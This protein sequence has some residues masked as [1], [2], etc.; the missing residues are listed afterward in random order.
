MVDS[1]LRTVKSM[2]MVPF[3]VKKTAAPLWNGN[4]RK[5]GGIP[6]QPDVATTFFSM[7]PDR[8][9]PQKKTEFS[10]LLSIRFSFSVAS[11]WPWCCLFSTDP[12][13]SPG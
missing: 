13:R 8:I 2:P 4:L 3:P 7:M 6:I 11:L 12:S 5:T 1:S 9:N 10:I